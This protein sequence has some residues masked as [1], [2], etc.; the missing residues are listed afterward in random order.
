MKFVFLHFKIS[1]KMIAYTLLILENIWKYHN[2][3]MISIRNDFLF[4][5]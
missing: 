1:V 2:F 4:Y 5:I 3:F